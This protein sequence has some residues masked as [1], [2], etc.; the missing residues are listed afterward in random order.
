MNVTDVTD[1]QILNLFKQSGK[2]SHIGVL[3]KKYSHS[4]L[5]LCLHYLKDTS[6]AEDA[7][8]DVF[9]FVLQNVNKYEIEGFK[10]WLMSVTRNH[11]LKKLTRSMKKEREI[12]DKNIEIPALENMESVEVKDHTNDKM[13]NKLELALDGL[14]P[15]QRECITLFYLNSYSYEEI[16]S[17]C[18]YSL[19]EVKSYIQNGKVNLKKSLGSSN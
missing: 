17:I 16:S 14:K 5:G 11:C 2:S 19:K 9:E 8:M 13:L 3:F 10:P 4:V 18:G 15:H 1:D 12:F 7:V 6:K